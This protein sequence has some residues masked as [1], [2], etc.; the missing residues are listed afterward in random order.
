MAEVVLARWPHELERVEAARA[1][2]TPR[3]LLVESTEPPPP[4][5]DPLEDWIRMPAPAAEVR[6]RV[7]TLVARACALTDDQRPCVDPD[8][9][10]H[11]AGRWV[12]LSRVEQALGRTLVDRF[13]AVVSRELLATR[14]WPGKAPSRNL[15]DVQM[16][17]VRRRVETVGLEV[18]TVRA[19]GYLM[20][21]APAGS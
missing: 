20:R 16:M 11:H 19:R 14:A 6:T 5:V 13:G 17:R 1:T 12:A 4:P 9:L 18:R 3:L 7:A 10:L 8:G 15:L 2:A 21:A